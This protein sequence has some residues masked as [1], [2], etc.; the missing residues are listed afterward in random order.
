MGLK[1]FYPD[2]NKWKARVVAMQERAIRLTERVR[3]LEE[4][5]R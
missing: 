4:H 5:V 2:A 1:D 3:L